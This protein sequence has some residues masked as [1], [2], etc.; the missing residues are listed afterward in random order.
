LAQD[1]H[2]AYRHTF[3]K[4]IEKDNFKDKTTGSGEGEVCFK[5]GKV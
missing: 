4:N 2:V 3:K 5:V 1:P